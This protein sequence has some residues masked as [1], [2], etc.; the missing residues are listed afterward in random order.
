MATIKGQKFSDIRNKTFAELLQNEELIKALVVDKENFLDISPTAEQQDLI[1]NPKKLIRNYIYPYKKTFDTTVEKKTM[2]SSSFT[3]FT[4]QGR[5]YRNGKVTFYVLTPTPLEKTNY[6]MRHD[7][8]C[9]IM[10]EIY[11]KTTIGEFSFESRGDFELDSQ[12][13]GH[14]I[15]FKLIEFHIV[16]KDDYNEL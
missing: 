1:D 4:K 2:I 5:N 11:T 15:T 10:E 14:Y 16:N 7:Y 3:G 9:D 13:I 6:G 8:I 12:Y